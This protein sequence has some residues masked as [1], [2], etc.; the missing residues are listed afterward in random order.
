MNPYIC[1]GLTDAVTGL[2]LALFD[3]IGWNTNIDVSTHPDYHFSTAQMFRAFAVPEPE[4]W[5]LMLAGLGLMAA[6][7]RRRRPA[8][9]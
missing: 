8:S 9:S 1:N 3:A 6:V 4:G 7:M 2:D 5:T